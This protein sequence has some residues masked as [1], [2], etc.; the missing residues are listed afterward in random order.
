MLSS[1][2]NLL[3]KDIP[4]LAIYGYAAQNHII[5]ETNKQRHHQSGK[6]KKDAKLNFISNYMFKHFIP[7]HT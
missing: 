4:E 3:E 1:G 6:K 5:T 7:T 2:L